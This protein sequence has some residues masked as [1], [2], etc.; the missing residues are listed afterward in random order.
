M[1]FDLEP[2]PDLT[3]ASPAAGFN[4]SY[5]GTMGLSSSEPS[6]ANGGYATAMGGPPQYNALSGSFGQL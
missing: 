5:S 1:L 4:G 6:L 2:A 3:R